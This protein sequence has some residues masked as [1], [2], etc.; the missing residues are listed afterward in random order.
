MESTDPEDV[1]EQGKREQPGRPFPR[2][3]AQY[4]Y[5]FVPAQLRMDTRDRAARQLPR[6]KVSWSSMVVTKKQSLGQNLACKFHV[7][8]IPLGRVMLIG[9]TSDIE[10]KQNSF[11]FSQLYGVAPW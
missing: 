6:G 4:S 10:L 5:D 7:L 8:E 9:L 2:D 1:P 11:S 3:T